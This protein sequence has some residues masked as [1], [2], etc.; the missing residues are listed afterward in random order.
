MGVSERLV[1]LGITVCAILGAIFTIIG[2]TT[3]MG[4]TDECYRKEVINGS[5]GCSVSDEVVVSLNN[6]E[7]KEVR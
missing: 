3:D 1:I 2:A 6:C 7:Y 5:E 4:G